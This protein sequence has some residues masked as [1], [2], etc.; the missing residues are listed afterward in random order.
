MFWLSLWSVKVYCVS[1]YIATASWTVCVPVF[2]SLSVPSV[3]SFDL[4]HILFLWGVV[5]LHTWFI[6]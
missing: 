1:G 5:F 6:L 3:C 2:A 4:S